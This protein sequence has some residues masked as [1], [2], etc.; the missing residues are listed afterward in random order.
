MQSWAYPQVGS[1]A[2]LVGM[3]VKTYHVLDLSPQQPESSGQ[4]CCKKNA[5][6]RHIVFCYLQ[7]QPADVMHDLFCHTDAVHGNIETLD[8]TNM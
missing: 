6:F 2:V 4:L 3:T 8:N 7:R 1:S 5:V